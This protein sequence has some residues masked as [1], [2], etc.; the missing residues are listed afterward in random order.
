LPHIRIINL[1]KTY[2]PIKALKDVSLEV[3]DGE[4]LSIVGPS[5]CGKTTLIKC[6]AGIVRPDKGEIYI[7]DKPILALPI[8][9]RNLGYVFQEIA[10]FPHMSVWDNISYGLMVKGIA[11]SKRRGQVREMLGMMGLEERAK[12]HPEELSGGARQKTALARALASGAR[13]LLLDEPLGALDAKVRA[14]LRYELRSLV[15]DLHLT[16]IHVT[17]DQEEALSISDR[18]AIMKAGSLV[19]VGTPWDLYMHPRHIFTARFLGEAN[20]MEGK[21]VAISGEDYLIDV[22]GLTLRA[23]SDPY[24][25]LELG[26]ACVL[27]IR[28]EFLSLR[29]EAPGS[30]NV[31]L[32]KGTLR[33]EVFMGDSLRYEVEV[34]K[35][36]SLLIRHPALLGELDLRVGDRAYVEI[37]KERLL[38]FPY[39]EGGLEAQLSLE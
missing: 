31:N 6:I 3:Q 17:H 28:P 9:D 30:S 10:L 24:Q 11:P 38:V 4:Y 27:A 20:F 12:A 21:V 26:N 29:K 34:E 16:A 37:P 18:V 13:L 14:V 35:G 1:T 23:P 19:E 32:W 7:D 5:G 15:K 33:E 39:P 36:I 2:G 25:P 22:G 8:E